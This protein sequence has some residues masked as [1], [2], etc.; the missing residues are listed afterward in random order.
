MALDLTWM[1]APDG[2]EI[3]APGCCV[4]TVK[5]DIS[6][7]LGMNIPKLREVFEQAGCTTT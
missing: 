1:L 3:D 6:D 2:A 5:G 7:W 4:E